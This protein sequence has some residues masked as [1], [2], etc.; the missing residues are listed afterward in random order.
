M[1]SNEQI[2]VAQVSADLGL[3]DRPCWGGG[4]REGCPPVFWIGLE[5]KDPLWS[6][7]NDERVPSRAES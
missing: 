7:L 3:D 4:A 2:M 1:L 6:S 5:R